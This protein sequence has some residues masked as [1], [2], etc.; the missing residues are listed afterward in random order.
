MIHEIRWKIA[1]SIAVQYQSHKA[2][3]RDCFFGVKSILYG[4][5]AKLPGR[6]SLHATAKKLVRQPGMNLQLQTFA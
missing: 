3:D 1:F 6:L 5:T 2:Q 4:D